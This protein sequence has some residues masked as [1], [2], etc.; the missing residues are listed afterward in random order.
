MVKVNRPES[1]PEVIAER[2]ALVEQLSAW[3]AAAAQPRPDA[4]SASTKASA[5]AFGV[6]TVAVDL[7]MALV[8][9]LQTVCVAVLL[10]R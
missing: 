8:A 9:V 1:L 10:A 5:Q 2:D 7:A 3:K 6:R 4:L